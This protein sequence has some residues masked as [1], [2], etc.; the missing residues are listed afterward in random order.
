MPSRMLHVAFIWHMHQPL[1]KDRLGG[2]Y[3]MPWVRLHGTKDYLDMVSILRHYPEIRQTFNLVPSLL[4]QVMDYARGDA[5]DR[6]QELTLAP[7]STWSASDRAYV[8]M[9]FFDVQWDRMLAPF[10]RY[11]QLALKRNDL[12]SQFTPEEASRAF[13]HQDL[14]D[15]TVW[16]NLA[17]FDPLWRKSDPDLAALVQRGQRFT[18]A[19]RELIVRKQRELLARIVPEYAEMRA[20]GQIELTTTPFYHPI[21]PLLVDSDSARVARPN[22]SLPRRA[23]RYP[24]DASEHIRRG[25]SYFEDRFG[26]RPTGMW[27]S[28]ESVSPAALDLMAREGIRWAVSDEGILARSLGQR[29]VRDASGRI[30]QPEILYRP[31]L[32]DTPSGPLSMVFRDVVLSDL[33]GFSYAKVPGAQ[34]AHDLHERLSGIAA[35]CPH[36]DPLVTIALDGENCWE[37]YSE[38]GW[39]FLRAFY[40]AVSADPGIQLVTVSDYL[41][42]HPPTA[43]IEEIFSGSWI[44][45]DFTTWI[46]DP[47]KNRAWDLLG[48]ARET[49]EHHDGPGRQAAYEELLAAEGSDWFWWFGQ[50]HDSGQDELFDQQFRLHLRNAY[51]LMGSVV[52]AELLEPVAPLPA[53]LALPEPASGTYDPSSGQAT[54]H[55]SAKAIS[56]I[57][58]SSDGKTVEFD[59]EMASQFGLDGNDELLILLCYPG[60]TRLNSP[61]NARPQPGLSGVTSRFLYAHE[62][63]IGLDSPQGVLSEAREVFTWDAGPVPVQVAIAKTSVH[64]EVPVIG[65]GQEPGRTIYFVVAAIRAGNLVEVLPGDRMLALALPVLTKLHPARP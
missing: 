43:R 55:A 23:F 62:I 47:V 57:E 61:I 27:P 38:D 28:E 39:D 41:A 40:D 51:E 32:V 7:I 63:R 37:H 45:S 50:G 60:Q 16:F 54:M 4:E 18:Q 33:I 22:L 42:K 5:V 36:P 48:Q 8:M 44:G 25:L 65:L 56:R 21:L 19:D 14:I 9:R 3:L 17:W 20:M 1:Y 49:Y 31:Y 58:Y 10:P 52:P 2:R 26:Y 11:H 64:V 46:G 29:L 34:A 6:A 35:S 12:L 53:T 59:L 24:Q 15:L 13:T 30:L